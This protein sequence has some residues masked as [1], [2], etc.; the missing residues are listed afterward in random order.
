MNF[1]GLIFSAAALFIMGIY[2]PIVIKAEYHFS[3]KIWPLFAAIGIACLIASL[4]LKGVISYTV[5]FLGA[6]NMWC[7][8]ELKQQAKR[9]AKGWFPKN[10]N[11][12]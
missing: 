2:H 5:A 7:I 4:Y 6:T 8:I 3:Q 9:V 12:H 1:D 11:K 10:P